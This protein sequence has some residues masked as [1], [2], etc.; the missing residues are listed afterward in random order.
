MPWSDIN[1]RKAD[2]LSIVDASL[3]GSGFKVQTVKPAGSASS[4][5]RQALHSSRGAGK[6]REEH[7]VGA[8]WCG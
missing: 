2:P 6:A 1:D 4:G 3:K 8:T 7:D 5:Q